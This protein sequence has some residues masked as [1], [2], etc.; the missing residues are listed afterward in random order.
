MWAFFYYFFLSLPEGGVGVGVGSGGLASAN[1]TRLAIRLGVIAEGRERW[2]A[3]G[4][5]SATIMTMRRK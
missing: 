3:G 1:G 5:A 4:E 2:V